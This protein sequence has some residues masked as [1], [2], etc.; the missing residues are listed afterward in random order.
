MHRVYIENKTNYNLLKTSHRTKGEF[1]S[2]NNFYL[3]HTTLDKKS[4]ITI[5][6]DGFLRPS[7]QQKKFRSMLSAEKLEYIYANINFDDIRNIKNVGG[8]KLFLD[9]KLFYDQT[10]FFNKG[11]QKYPTEASIHIDKNESE[12]SKRDKLMKI[13]EYVKNPT[14]HSQHLQLEK[15]AP[16]L[17]HEILFNSEIDL[18]KYLIGIEC[19]EVD[20]KIFEKIIKKYNY[21]NVK[22]FIGV[23]NDKGN[24]DAP[25]LIYFT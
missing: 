1:N 25:S 14:H 9:S 19:N 13:K 10:S 20:K 6:K 4:L 21:E 3:I 11:W 17:V 8:Y 12:R 15:Y 16:H 2:Y 18:K 24:I 23:I 5:L 7:I 22:I